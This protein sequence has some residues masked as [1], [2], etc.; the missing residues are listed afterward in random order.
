MRQL[1]RW[2]SAE[3]GQSYAL[4]RQPDLLVTPTAKP[5]A[6]L[7]KV[8]PTHTYQSIL[9]LGSSFDEATIYPIF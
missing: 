9:G 7:I 2:F 5:Q 1:K 6:T 4:D 8:D 3:D